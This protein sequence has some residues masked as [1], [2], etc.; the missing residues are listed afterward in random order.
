[1]LTLIDV[2]NDSKL[3]HFENFESMRVW[4]QDNRIIPGRYCVISVDDFHQVQEVFFVDVVE[5]VGED[6][7]TF[8]GIPFEQFAMSSQIK[9]SIRIDDL[10]FGSF[11]IWRKWQLIQLFD[12][13]KPG[14]EVQIRLEG[15]KFFKVQYCPGEKNLVLYRSSNS[16]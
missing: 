9:G 15:D 4:V 1:M 12:S 6:K 11:T 13:L 16:Y 3:G 2:Q 14:V 7:I 8:D 10:L 5:Q